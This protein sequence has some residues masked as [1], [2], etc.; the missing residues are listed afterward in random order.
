MAPGASSARLSS[1][2]KGRTGQDG[3]TGGAEGKEEE[4]RKYEFK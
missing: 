2:G 1:D 3:R 4:V